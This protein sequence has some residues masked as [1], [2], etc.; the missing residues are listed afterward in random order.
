MQPQLPLSGS[1]QT[2]PRVEIF[3]KSTG[4]TSKHSQD[5]QMGRLNRELRED[6]D[7]KKP[8]VVRPVRKHRLYSTDGAEP[9]PTL[10]QIEQLGPLTPLERATY[11]VFAATLTEFKVIPESCA[12]AITREDALDRIYELAGQSSSLGDLKNEA[13][14]FRNLKSRVNARFKPFGWKSWSTD[15]VIVEPL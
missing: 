5:I 15:H 12:H 1:G 14:S 4:S 13:N 2:R 6:G 10:E 7:P 11:Q 8:D 3:A 9:F